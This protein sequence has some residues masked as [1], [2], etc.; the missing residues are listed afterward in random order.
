PYQEKTLMII[1]EK[2]PTVVLINNKKISAAFKKQF[3]VLW[4]QRVKTY[5]GDEGVK[6]IITVVEDKG[7]KDGYKKWFDYLWS[8]A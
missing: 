4:G 6:T 8:Q 5:E 2:E 3:E 7:I 1:Q